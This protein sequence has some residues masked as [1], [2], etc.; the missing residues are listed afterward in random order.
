MTG[1]PPE[2]FHSRV[3]KLREIMDEEKVDIFLIYGDEYRRENLRYVSNYW[4]IFERGMLAVAIESDP[5]LLVAPECQHYA[6]EMSVWKDIRM[7]H[8]MEMAYVPEH[9][10]FSSDTVFSTLNQIFLDMLKGRKPRRIRV[11]GVDAMSVLT[12]DA[13][14]SASPEAEIINSDQILYKMRLIKSQAEIEMLKRAWEIC[15]IGY[16]AILDADLI[17]LTEIQAAAIGEKAARDAGTEHIVFSIFA[18]GER[19]N[20]VIGRPN[21]KI[22]FDEEMIMS[23]LAIQ[24]HGYIASN[25][26]PFVAGK[27]YSMKQRKLIEH[28]IKAES[29]A[30]KNIRNG[31]VAGEVVG[32]IKEYFKA[33]G[34]EKYD[35]YPPI[36]GN[37][38]AEAESPYPDEHSTYAFETGMGVNMDVSLFGIPGV[39]SNRIEE[40]FIVSDD[41]VIVLSKLINRLREEFLADLNG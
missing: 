1:L 7:I 38:L 25:A 28:L 13:I 2:E 3:K 22:I 12:Y 4:P 15:D 20:S 17:G 37:G 14:K 29:I 21:E 32:K 40:G 24:Y 18:S 30:V 16:K 35:L 11:C 31:A 8:E 23:S 19:T 9:V 39:G 36:H 6:R 33:N 10:G 34:L 27:K 41:G 26:W 5:V